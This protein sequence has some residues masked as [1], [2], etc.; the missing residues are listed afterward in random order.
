MAKK[1]AKKKN[2]K[3]SKSLKKT[4]QAKKAKKL[5]R[6]TDKKV[7]AGVLAGIAEYFNYDPTLVRLLF[8][9]LVLVTGVIP[10]ILIYILAALLIPKKVY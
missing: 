8:I 7:L 2:V 10:G 6:A 4:K 1:Q 5:Y 9:L 3:S